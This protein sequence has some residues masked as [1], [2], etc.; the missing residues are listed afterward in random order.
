MAEEQDAEDRT[1]PASPQRLK[2]AREE[3]DVAVSIDAVHVATMAG[4]G[5]ALAMAAP[6]AGRALLD[7]GR[8][9]FAGAATTTAG[10]ALADLL[11][12]ALPLALGVPALGAAAA[13]AAGLLQTGF[14][15]SGK[16]LVPKPEKLSPIA[17][18]KRLFGEQGWTEFIK[19]LLKLGIVG[20]TLWWSAGDAAALLTALAQGPE[21]LAGTAASLLGGLLAAA[22]AAMAAL[23]AADYL[24]IHQR[25]ARRL[26]M[27]RQELRD[28]MKE[29][30]GDP[31]LKA[32]RRARMRRQSRRRTLAATAQA[33][34]VVTNPTHYAVALSYDRGRDAAPRIVAKGV[35]E[36]A[37]RMRETAE[38][39]GVPIIP[40]PPLARA[41]HRLDEG[42]PVPEEHFKAVAEIIALVMRLRGPAA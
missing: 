30:E 10:D 37:A 18:F 19:N 2:K 4:A 35:D 32:H 8:D 12:A 9:V 7:A 15:L 41:L 36:L 6:S 26:R 38:R 28:E 1:E 14:L 20:A 16:N 33:T 21:T 42:T 39:H 5:L 13:L 29:S 31:H 3:G 23:A 22:L 40:N 24:W 17:G 25:R 34:V 11:W 27:S